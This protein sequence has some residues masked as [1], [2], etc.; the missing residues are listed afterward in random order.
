M[1]EIIVEDITR[2]DVEAIVNAANPSLRRRRGRRDTKRPRKTEPF[3]AVLRL[4]PK[5]AKIVP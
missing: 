5:R 3:Y 1:L 2:V 4:R